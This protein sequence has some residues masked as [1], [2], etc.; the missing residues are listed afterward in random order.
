[1][2]SAEQSFLASLYILT[3]I[4]TVVSGLHSTNQL[5]V[6]TG[7]PGDVSVMQRFLPQMAQ[8]CNVF[9]DDSCYGHANKEMYRKFLLRYQSEPP[10][11]PCLLVKATTET[12]VVACNTGSTFGHLKLDRDA[13]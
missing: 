7:S 1:M 8:L 4:Y 5:I 12:A 10:F 6:C 11:Y 9:T 2:H 3:L 13:G